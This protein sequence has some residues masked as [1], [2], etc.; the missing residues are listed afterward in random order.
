M[1][2]SSVSFSKQGN[3]YISDAIDVTGNAIALQIKYA[4][5]GG[6]VLERSI[7]GTTWVT[8]AMPILASNS[9]GIPAIETN[10]TG[11]VTG[12]KLRIKFYK[13]V[14]PSAINVLQ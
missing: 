10:V 13:G 3:I 11:L 2:V 7:D 14:V 1:A 4:K 6:T 9:N 8:A 5:S 12:Q